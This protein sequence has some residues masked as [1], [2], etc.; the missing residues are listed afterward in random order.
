MNPL[1]L[2]NDLYNEMYT[3]LQ[4]LE[5][6]TNPALQAAAGKC[7]CLKYF[8]RLRERLLGETTLD[9]GSEIQ[10]FKQIKPVFSAWLF[11]YDRLFE[12][13]TRRKPCGDRSF[14]KPLK[15]LRKQMKKF[16]KRNHDIITYCQLGQTKLDEYY[17]LRC[18]YDC[19][20]KDDHTA[21]DVAFCT[22]YDDTVAKMI[23]YEMLEKYADELEAGAVTEAGQACSTGRKRLTWTA[24]KAYLGE[25]IY[26]LHATEVFNQGKATLS[27]IAAELGAFF[28]MP[29]KDIY[30]ILK[31]LKARAKTKTPFLDKA[32]QCMNL[33]LNE[34]DNP[35]K[36]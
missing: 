30:N 25:L 34:T 35:Y 6:E 13:H 18:S 27:E 26:A 24:A 36:Y 9:K 2:H 8:I 29:I 15:W 4:T 10:F 20:L 28:N 16:H 1:P 5:P 33:M 32:Y 7:I 11:Y 31:D 17:F 21:F 22:N 14:R 19:K 12:F 3:E 23:G